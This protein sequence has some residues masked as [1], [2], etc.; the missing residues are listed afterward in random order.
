MNMRRIISILAVSLLAAG[1][2]ASGA[3]A[4][5]VS[6]GVTSADVEYVKF[7]PFEVATAT[8]VRIIDDYMY[9]SSW[10]NIS[11]YDVS[12]PLD[13]QLISITPIGFEFESEDMPT[14]GEVLLFSE[15]LPGDALHVWDVTEKTA[16]VEIATLNGAG[17]HTS[18]CL[19][20]CQ[21]VYGSGGTITD[22]R[23]PANPKLAGSWTELS[24]ASGGH[25]VTEVRPGLVLVAS[26]EGALLDTTDPTAPRIVAKAGGGAPRPQHS[27]RWPNEGADRFIL[28]QSESNAN[29]Q[30]TED[31][32]ETSFSSWDST[33]WSK[34]QFY[35][36]VDSYV[37]Q[38]GTA[39]DGNAPVNGLGCS[40]HWFEANPR[41]LNGG[42]VAMGAYEHGTRF[43]WIDADGAIT[44]IGYFLPFGGSTSGDWWL[45]DQIVY[46]IDYT[47]GIDILKWNGELDPPKPAR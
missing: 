36:N 27:S 30:C 24:G 23:D 42:L 13:P 45:T 21:W 5:R 40:A 16:P 6:H 46:A 25:D 34:S 31:D 3:G 12:N 14:N 22:L 8:G 35:E 33:G 4:Q 39:M 11:I 7:V 18:T 10:K 1:A 38:T 47:R 37:L 26:S 15:E 9:L 17:N 44:E 32:G 2:L 29:P 28:G 20:D 41:F 19:Y 43:L